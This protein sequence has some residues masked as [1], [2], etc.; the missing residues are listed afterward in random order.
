MCLSLEN[1]VGNCCSL[2]QVEINTDGSASIYDD[3]HGFDLSVVR[4]LGKTTIEVLLTELLACR[5]AKIDEHVREQLCRAGVVVT[6]SLSEWLVIETAQDGWLWRQQYER[7]EPVSAISKV[8]P[9]TDSWQRMSFLPDASIL[10]S[11]DFRVD[12]V[13][14]W[15]EELTID[16]GDVAI[17]LED[18]RDGSS[19]RL[20]PRSS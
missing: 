16:F 4:S 7:G 8:E 15:F 17:T 6:N 14:E 3:G 12:L 13:K 2:I 10:E 11:T 9:A 5:D 18:K 1:A 20:H 19:H